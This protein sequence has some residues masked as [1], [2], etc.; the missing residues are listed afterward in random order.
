MRIRFAYEIPSRL[1][2][3]DV[4]RAVGDLVHVG[5][6]HRSEFALPTRTA[7]RSPPIAVRLQAAWAYGADRC[8]PR[9]STVTRISIAF[10][11]AC[12]SALMEDG[13]KALSKCYA[14]V[15]ADGRR[16]SR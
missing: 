12:P 4:E 10:S 1:A 14:P 7:L 16:G 2:H 15:D 11:T 3:D 9:R 6:L 5:R 8:R 13:R